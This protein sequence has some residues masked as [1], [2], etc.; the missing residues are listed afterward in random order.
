MVKVKQSLFLICACGLFCSIIWT[1]ILVFFVS[2][3][4]TLYYQ[5]VLSRKILSLED[6]IIR[7]ATSMSTNHATSLHFLYRN[8]RR[9]VEGLNHLQ[10]ALYSSVKRILPKSFPKQNNDTFYEQMIRRQRIS[11][12]CQAFASSE[13]GMSSS[14]YPGRSPLFSQTIQRDA[15]LIAQTPPSVLCYNHK[16]ASST[17]MS[18]FTKLLG[19]EVYFQQLLESGAF[20]K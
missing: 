14:W 10:K 16:V 1:I 4:S 18:A 7:Y 6:L 2:K 12:V 20:Y 8:Q 15:F 19:D 9:S 3:P 17:W 5:D 13:E 11:D